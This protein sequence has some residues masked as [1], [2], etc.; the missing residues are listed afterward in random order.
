MANS[1]MNCQTISKK[2]QFSAEKCK[3]LHVGKYQDKYRCPTLCV[4]NW[5]ETETRNEIT[6]GM[7]I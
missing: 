4:D 5:K 7:E 6:G 3:K 1:F 2:L